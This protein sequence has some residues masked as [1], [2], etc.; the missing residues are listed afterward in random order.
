MSGTTIHKQARTTPQL[1]EEI[2]NSS[3]SEGTLGEKYDIS[4]STVRKWKHQETT[5][6]RSHRP[7]R[8]HTALSA[9]QEAVVVELRRS[10]C[11]C[12]PMTCWWPSGSSSS[13]T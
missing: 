12:P 9:A 7:H 11:C 4:R 1:R 3:L 6:D 2:R 10:R 13:R 8:L 5:A